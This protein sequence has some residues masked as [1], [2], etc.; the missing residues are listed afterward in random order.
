MASLTND[1]RPSYCLSH[2]QLNKLPVMFMWRHFS[3]TERIPQD[4]LPWYFRGC[5]LCQPCTP[6]TSNL[7]Q[8]HQLM[9]A[10]TCAVA[11]FLAS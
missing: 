1:R 4:S 9:L 5:C 6:H 3:H 2:E 7:D 8:V 11:R 10:S